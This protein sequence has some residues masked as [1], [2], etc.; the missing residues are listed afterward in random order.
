MKLNYKQNLERQVNLLS[1]FK[2]QLE[3]MH[4]NLK[5]QMELPDK[6]NEVLLVSA[7]RISEY[8]ATTERAL[9]LI[10]EEPDAG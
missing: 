4:S 1:N 3:S 2:W 8:I 10:K 5:A 9:L 7:Q 6:L